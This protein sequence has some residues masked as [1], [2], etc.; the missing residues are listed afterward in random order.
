MDLYSV[1][2]CFEATTRRQTQ[3][4]VFGG[5]GRNSAT[6]KKEEK[7][8]G[9]FIDRDWG[10]TCRCDEYTLYYCRYDEYDSCTFDVTFTSTRN[11]AL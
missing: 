7:E 11:A 4:T 2:L 10:F 5:G 9:G 6:E 3:C 1:H 8:G